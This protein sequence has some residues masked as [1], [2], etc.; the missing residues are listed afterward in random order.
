MLVVTFFLRTV[1]HLGRLFTA[2]V[3]TDIVIAR[4]AYTV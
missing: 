3:S 2:V 4:P 1:D